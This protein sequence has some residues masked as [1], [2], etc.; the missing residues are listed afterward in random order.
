MKTLRSVSIVLLVLYAVMTSYSVL[1]ISVGAGYNPVLLPL[2][3]I[4][5]FSFA[6]LHGVQRLGWK[7]LILLL[8]STVIISLAFES[9]GVAT[10]AIYGNYHYTEKLG[11]KFLDLVPY[12]IPVA[13]FMVS[14]PAFIIAVRLVPVVR[15]VWT[16]RLLVGAVGAMAMTAWD[17]AM[18]PMMVAGGHWIW[19]QGGEYF[20][21]PAQN[22]WG[23]WLTIFVAFLFF[24]VVGGITPDGV[25]KR[26]NGFD[27]LVILSYVLAGLSSIVMDFQI[28]LAGP[29]LVGIF[30]MTP[31]AVMGWLMEYSQP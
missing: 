1:S 5:A 3:A 6:A 19:E 11:P 14:Y 24:L 8:A 13:W 30:A 28:G 29:A 22:F 18:D 15:G 21:I 10:G 4:T 20:N 12:L 26:Q 23:W 2:S 17:L 27:Q 16:W 31:W 7:P 9:V 25:K